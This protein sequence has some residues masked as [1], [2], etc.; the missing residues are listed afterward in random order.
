VNRDKFDHEQKDAMIC[1]AIGE[2]PRMNTSDATVKDGDIK[3]I[4]M[5]IHQG[6][7]SLTT[8]PSFSMFQMVFPMLVISGSP[9]HVDD[10]ESQL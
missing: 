5:E 2:I 10:G 6:V 8:I 1:D 9:D 3:C 4:N 7:G